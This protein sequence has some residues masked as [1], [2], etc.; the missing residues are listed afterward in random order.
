[1]S[2][3]VRELAYKCAVAHQLKKK[4]RPE[5]VVYRLLKAAH[6]AVTEKTRDY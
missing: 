4:K 3:E 2:S 5:R 6:N 1:M